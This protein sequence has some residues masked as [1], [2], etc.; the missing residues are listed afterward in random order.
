MIISVLF[1]KICSRDSKIRKS[2]LLS[3]NCVMYFFWTYAIIYW[4]CRMRAFNFACKSHFSVVW[5]LS[6]SC[7]CRGV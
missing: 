7:Q 6:S 1:F 4:W 2:F 5:I 3:F